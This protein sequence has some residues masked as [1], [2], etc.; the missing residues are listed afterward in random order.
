MVLNRSCWLEVRRP[1]NLSLPLKQMVTKACK[2]QKVKLWHTPA[3]SP[4]LNPV[5]RFWAWLKHK[6]RK[7]DLTDALQNRPL[8]SKKAYRDRIRRVVRSKKAAETAGN[9]AKSF[10]KV[11]RTVAAKRGAASGF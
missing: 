5:E 3:K 7:M 10:R 9:I 4:D 6:L 11:C 8:L 2:K 1:A